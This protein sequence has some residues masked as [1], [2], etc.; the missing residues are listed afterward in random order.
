MIFD[1]HTNGALTDLESDVCII[2]SGAAGLAVA[3]ELGNT[4][5]SV[6]VLEGGGEQFEDATQKLYDVEIDGSAYTGAHD[7]RFRVF[8]GSTTRWG[9]QALP[10]TSL[11]FEERD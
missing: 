7:G 9:G 11:D 4:A 3:T 6:V 8:G 2:G 1:L 5:L 10:L